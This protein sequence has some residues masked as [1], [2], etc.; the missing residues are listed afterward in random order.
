MSD[1][2]GQ[3]VEMLH[4]KISRKLIVKWGHYGYFSEVN[5]V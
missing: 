2:C 4:I 3:R 5:F 1:I